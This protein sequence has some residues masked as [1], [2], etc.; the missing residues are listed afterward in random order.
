MPRQLTVL[1]IDD[2]LFIRESLSA[3]LEDRDFF[4]LKAS[5]GRQGL[6]LFREQ[7]PDI[8]L[9]DL[10]MPE[11]DGLAVLE[12]VRDESP[13]TPVI[14]ISG[15]GAMK[16][17]IDAL[18]LG[19]WNYITKPIEDLDVLGHAIDTC[20]ERVK[21]MT[22]NERYR[23]RLEDLVEER[24]RQL[25]Q[26]MEV[27]DYLA[28]LSQA[29]L[30]MDDMDDMAAQVGATLA[31]L[32]GSS[33]G[34]A[35]YYDA[36]GQMHCPQFEDDSQ[37]D[38]LTQAVMMQEETL[39]ESTAC[40]KAL[41]IPILSQKQRKGLLLAAGREE[42]YSEGACRAAR[43]VAAVFSLALERERLFFELELERKTASTALKVKS[44]FLSQMSHELRTPLAG[45]MG[46]LELILKAGD[47]DG[48]RE[49][50][51][52]ASKSARELLELINRI[53]QFVNLARN[54]FQPEMQRFSIP[55]LIQEICLGYLEKAQQKGVEL[56]WTLE[57]GLPKHFESDPEAVRQIIVALVDNAIKFSSEGQTRVQVAGTQ[58]NELLVLVMDQG[59]GIP[60]EDQEVIFDQF[61]QLED[62]YTRVHGGAGLGLAMARRLAEHLNGRLTVD[63]EP[64]RGACFA[65]RLPSS[66]SQMKGR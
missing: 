35:I 27:S 66:A 20:L 4:V 23:E 55:Q 15:T 56:L 19:A 50:A 45:T 26:E 61:T 9:V 29:I 48:A 22:E 44:T 42:G 33:L 51:R 43:K 38:L 14:V 18:R 62:V 28:E 52:G 57:E 2:E 59:P 10:R 30:T 6:E 7:N 53:L 47:L 24:T 60:L 32:T 17:V 21:L 58:E 65:L 3:W 8:V 40:G 5:N 31:K 54:E 63:S 34:V 25:R 49:L 13:S 41:V 37:H 1:C 12:A 39:L 36:T 64:G 46:M 11:M 16:D